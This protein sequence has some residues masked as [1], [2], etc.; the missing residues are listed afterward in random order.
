MALRLVSQRVLAQSANSVR[1]AASASLL[2]TASTA[3]VAHSTAESEIPSVRDVMLG[4]TFVDPSGA[5]RKVPGII[6]KT[7]YDISEM[8]GIEL[9]P[10]SVG[11]PADAIRSAEWTEPLFGEGPCTGFDHVLLVGP[12]VETAKP[13][14]HI[15]M[16]MLN[17]YWDDDEIFPE[18]RLATQITLT[19]EMDGM[20]VYVPDRICDDI[21]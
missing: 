3:A 17:H 14:D 16:R 13:R 7:L 5:R 21:P 15:E 9:G 11:G 10:A 8:H 2:R 19:K 12:G 6:G 18:S 20:I 1:K 4:L